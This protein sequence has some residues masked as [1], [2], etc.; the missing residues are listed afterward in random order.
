MT[1]CR[2]L[3]SSSDDKSVL[4]VLR[5][6]GNHLVS[7]F[8]S[9]QLSAGVFTAVAG[10][11]DLD[12]KGAL[13]VP[14]CDGALR[15]RP[16]T[17]SAPRKSPL[18]EH[19]AST[20]PSLLAM[21]WRLATLRASST[22]W[23]LHLLRFAELAG[24]APTWLG[25]RKS[26]HRS[27]LD[28]LEGSSAEATYRSLLDKTITLQGQFD[29]EEWQAVLPLVTEIGSHVAQ[30]TKL[31]QPAIDFLT[32]PDALQRQPAE[33]SSSQTIL[34][35]YSHPPEEPKVHI[36]LG[37]IHSVKGETH[38]ATLVLDSFYYK[39]HLSELKPW[40][41]GER[42]GGMK[43]KAKGKPELENS[44]LLGRLKLHYV[45]MTRPLASALPGYE[46]G[47]VH[48]SRT[49]TTGDPRMAAR[50]LQC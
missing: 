50:G 9:Q 11:H 14:P 15:A 29:A 18:Q 44:R 6:Y 10:V 36:R 21:R 19:S 45:A 17:R 27:V 35:F 30:A 42:A 34:N 43:K 37:S 49:E 13:S 24:A 7:I 46:A 28:A 16:T 5:H 1:H 22:R 41:L 3:S 40:I 32:G 48:R 4:D 2:Q 26:A 20:S 8:D 38:T 47:C 33:G 12:D 23:R 25:G 31:P 39:H